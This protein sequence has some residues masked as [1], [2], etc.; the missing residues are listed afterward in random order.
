VKAKRK[1][2]LLVNFVLG[3]IVILIAAYLRRLA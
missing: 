3:V 2:W 1:T